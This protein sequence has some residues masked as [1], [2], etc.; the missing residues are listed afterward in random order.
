MESSPQGK[1]S[2]TPVVVVL[3]E[4]VQFGTE[5]VT[6]IVLQRVTGG[7]LRHINMPVA[8]EG[9]APP[10]HYFLEI[11]SAA[12]GYPPAVFDL[13]TPW[14]MSAVTKAVIALVSPSEGT[15]EQA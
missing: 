13:L 12:S 9:E 10:P 11:A 2:K 14:D 3:S 5:R 8:Q 1:A 15:T 6:Q 4:P 7:M